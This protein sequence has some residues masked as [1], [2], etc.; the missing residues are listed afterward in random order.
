MDVMIDIETLS[1]SPQALVLAIGVVG[2]NVKTGQTKTLMQSSIDYS[3]EANGRMLTTQFAIDAETV[4]FWMCQDKEAIELLEFNKKP[5]THVLIE[6]NDA[7]AYAQAD[8]EDHIRVWAKDPTFDLVILRHAFTQTHLVPA[9]EF[10]QER[11]V[12][13]IVDLAQIKS[14]DSFS[15]VKP[16]IAHSAL[17]DAE[18]Q[19][20]TVINAFKVL[21]GE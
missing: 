19:A 1:T 9:W 8:A 15:A 20:K 14:A 21:I 3:Y 18:A 13:T 6:L 4:K 16:T 12:R 10:W 5:I 17:H 7:I 2:F 11:A